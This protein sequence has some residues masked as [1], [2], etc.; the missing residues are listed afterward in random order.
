[1]C[2]MCMQNPRRPQEGEDIR[3][4]RTEVT[5]NC[6]W[7]CRSREMNLSPSQEQQVLLTAEPHVWQTF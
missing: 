5:G 7:P 4:P 6:R 3:S 1:M 2:T